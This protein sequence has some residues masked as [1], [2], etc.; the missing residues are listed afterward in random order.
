MSNASYLD[1]R[2]R[3]A[4]LGGLSWDPAGVKLLHDTRGCCLPSVPRLAESLPWESLREM[5]AGTAGFREKCLASW[6]AQGRVSA[7]HNG[8]GSVGTGGKGSSLETAPGNYARFS[9]DPM[10]DPATWSIR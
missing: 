2:P 3:G 1:V 5:H 4:F 8:F 6:L 7:P 9:G 10:L